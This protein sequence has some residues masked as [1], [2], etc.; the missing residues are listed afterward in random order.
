[1]RGSFLGPAALFITGCYTGLSTAQSG[2]DASEGAASAS[3]GS[4]SDTGSDLPVPDDV[5]EEIGISGL[6][7][8]SIAEYTQ[9]V[10]DLLGMTP[11]QVQ[12]LLPADTLT[13]FDNDYT[14]Q[15]ASEA[16]VKGLE[17]LAGDIADAVVADATLRSALVPCTPTGPDDAACYREFLTSFGRRALRRTLS[18]EEL[19]RFAVL[20]SYGVDEGDF[21]AG[22]AAA[23]RM[24]LQHPELVYRVE[25]GT[26]VPDA[27]DLF[28]LNGW[29]VGARLS[30][31][32][33]GSTPPDWLLDA[34]EAGELDTSEGIASAAVMLLDD[35]R[36][37]ARVVRFHSLWLAYANLSETGVYA[38]MHT[39]TAALVERIVFDDRRPWVDMLTSNET[40][41]TPELAE[42]YGLPVPAEP[43][44]VAYPDDG[45][46]GL[47][48][49]G[50]FLSV[51]AKFGDTSPTQRGKL[52]R[53][54]L[55]CQEIPKPPPDL[56]VDVCA[57]PPAD[58]DACKIDRYFMSH[59]DACKGCHEQMDPIGFG[60]ENYDASGVFRTTDLD[61]PE[62]VIAGDGDFVGLGTFNGPAQLA[63]L[64]VESDG[65][66]P[67]VAQQL[68]RFA[69]GRTELDVHD[70]T[71]VQRVADESSVDGQL[72][73]LAFIT[74]YVGAEAF[75]YR[76]EE[77][78]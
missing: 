41:L 5:A 75:R 53:T 18:D 40:W 57:P 37:R 58:P 43:S 13:P 27:P 64:A 50:T 59:E 11:E 68:Y 78:P 51:G 52:V 77:S 54:K 67:C 32:L 62:C 72:D 6:R 47:L 76:R 30:Y 7:R 73:M 31:F 33:V 36:A 56:M 29:E 34:A 25:L 42:H 21:W 39:E 65:L 26:P 74:G 45:R 22:I 28:R 60:L 49:H 61:R 70:G 16:L 15:T 46:A 2:D 17:L 8:L 10:I 14:T 24:F 48:S 1:M 4:G 71:L 66:E 44:W 12:E 3:D 9:T 20:Q 55:F 19:D 35:P 69:V 23:L 63:A 38:D